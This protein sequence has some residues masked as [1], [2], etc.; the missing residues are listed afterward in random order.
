MFLI[1]AEEYGFVHAAIMLF[2]VIGHCLCNQLGTLFKNDLSIKIQCIVNPVINH[3][4]GVI[5]LA[6]V[7]NESFYILVKEHTDNTIRSEVA[8]VDTLFQGV[9]VDR[10]SK[11]VNI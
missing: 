8:I 6:G 1:D 3:F 11:V 10:I 2:Q 7:R 5:C 9:G 4:A